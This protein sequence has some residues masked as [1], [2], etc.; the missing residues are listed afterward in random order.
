M[1]RW[2]TP[3][4]EP[5]SSSRE[6]AY[7]A[8]FDPVAGD[9]VQPV[10]APGEWDALPS[11]DPSKR[12]MARWTH[13]GSP[14]GCDNCGERCQVCNDRMCATWGPEP[15]PRC[16]AHPTCVECAEPPTC[17]ECRLISGEGLE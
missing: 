10:M 5:Y 2:A 6:R 8:G 15:T 9:G 17:I 11:D 7:D 1:I 4:P 16:P 13:Q 12:R 14:N 3:Q